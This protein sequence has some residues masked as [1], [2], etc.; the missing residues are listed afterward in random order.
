MSNAS[1]QANY[2][3]PP[4]RG[5]ILCLA[6]TTSTAFVD[7][8]TEVNTKLGADEIAGTTQPGKERLFC[9]RYLTLTAEG[10][11]VYVA[12]SQTATGALVPATNSAVDAG[13]KAPTPDA[14]LEECLLIP[15]G[16]SVQF[17]MDGEGTLFKYL[18]YIGSAS[19]QLRIVPS[20]PREIRERR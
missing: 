7:L 3:A 13:T 19:C 5:Q 11:D 12:L 18:A 14:D 20:S 16:T 8:T 15:D 9:G 10:G 6:V 2:V 17:L 4:R 1:R